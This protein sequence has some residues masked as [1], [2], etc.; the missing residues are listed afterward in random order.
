MIVQVFPVSVF[1][2]NA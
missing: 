1:V 2:Q